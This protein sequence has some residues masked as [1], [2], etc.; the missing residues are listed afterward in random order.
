ME[1]EIPCRWNIG[2]GEAQENLSGDL[3]GMGNRYL[4]TQLHSQELLLR[5]VH[6]QPCFDEIHNFLEEKAVTWESFRS[7]K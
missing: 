2:S 5:I 6:A 3:H 1:M 4:F 7:P